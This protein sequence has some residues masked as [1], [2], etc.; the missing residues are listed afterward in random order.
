M[1]GSVVTAA[2][3]RTNA[4]YESCH[5]TNISLEQTIM[6]ERVSKIKDSYQ[7]NVKRFNNKIVTYIHDS[8]NIVS[9]VCASSSSLLF[10][11]IDLACRIYDR[12]TL[13]LWQG[14]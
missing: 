10:V 13:I 1:L 6:N 14:K 8:R 4:V 9:V 7:L 2:H 5:G 11:V 12:V 3:R